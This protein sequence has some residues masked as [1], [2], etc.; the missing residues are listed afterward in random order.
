MD[1]LIFVAAVPV[2]VSLY[3]V[4]K[5]QRF[6]FL[7]GYFLF[8][9]IVIPDQLST[10]LSDDGTALNLAL[11][12]IWLLQA[13]IAFPNK[14]NYDGSKVFRSFAIKTFISLAS[15]QCFRRPI[16][17]DGQQ[18]RRGHAHCG[19]I[20]SR[21]PRAFPCDCHL[22]HVEQ[23]DSRWHQRLTVFLSELRSL[24]IRGC[25]FRGAALY[26]YE[27]DTILIPYNS[28]MLY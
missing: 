13:I 5:R 21:H 1:P 27:H 20:V 11:A 9:L 16:D 7:L 4:I 18:H 3:G 15:D 23:Q 8:S 2:L 17:P 26:F 6:F 10:Y 14:L 25:I 28:T 24:K 12:L 19:R 22:P